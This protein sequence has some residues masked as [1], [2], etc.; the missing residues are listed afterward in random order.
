MISVQPTTLMKKSIPLALYLA[1]LG[2]MLFLPVCLELSSAILFASGFGIIF[3]HDYT[4]VCR[5]APLTRDGALDPVREFQATGKKTR[6]EK[7]PLAA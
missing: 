7:H 4:R 6:D 2:A 5:S 1:T 3:A